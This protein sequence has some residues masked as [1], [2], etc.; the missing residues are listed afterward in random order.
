MLLSFFVSVLF[1]AG[2]TPLTFNLTDQGVYT[3]DRLSLHK[4]GDHYLFSDG[5]DNTSLS[6]VD[7][8]GKELFRYAKA[9]QGPG[10]LNQHSVFGI[11]S[12]K[13]YVHSRGAGIL[14]FDHQ[15]QLV[16]KN[17]YKFEQSYA[18]VRPIGVAL[19]GG[20]FL[21]HGNPFLSHHFALFDLSDLQKQEPWKAKQPL[22]ENER[23]QDRL[24]QV[25]SSFHHRYLFTSQWAV[26]PDEPEYRV[27][28]FTQLKNQWPQVAELSYT[29]ED[30]KPLYPETLALIVSGFRIG[31]YYV[32]RL[33]SG[34]EGY[35]GHERWHISLDVF[36]VNG[37]FLKRISKPGLRIVQVKNSDEV[38][39]YEER[40]DDY[41][42]AF[43]IEAFLK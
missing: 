27:K 40:D 11:M 5:G 12:D 42:V 4:V 29:A 31:D 19:E 23:S 43:D 16:S 13:I 28:V 25:R 8:R 7:V 20:Q 36:D 24:R 39:M 21:V 32:V 15:L 2:K 1:F 3:I 22:I 30:L 18:M 9:G 6:V 33:M 37:Q 10:E 17:E 34:L 14:I 26:L 35:S 41:L 38:F